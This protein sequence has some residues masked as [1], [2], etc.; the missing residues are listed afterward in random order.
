[1]ALWLIERYGVAVDSAIHAPVMDHGDDAR[2][3]HAHIL[4][5]TRVITASGLGKKT[6]I[7][8][9]KVT[10]SAETLV[11]REVWETLLNDALMR[12][13]FDEAI[14]DRRTLEEQGIDRTPQIHIGKKSKAAQ[15][16]EGRETASD[17]DDEEDGEGDTES[18][19]SGKGDS[20]PPKA[21]QEDA[22]EDS[23]AAD[24]DTRMDKVYDQT[25]RG[26]RSDLVQEIKALNLKRAAFE[27]IPLDQQILDLEHLMEKLDS[28]IDRLTQLKE[29]TSLSSQVKELLKQLFEFISRDKADISLVHKNRDIRAAQK[30]AQIKRYGRAYREGIHSQMQRMESYIE[31]VQQKQNDYAAYKS[32]VDEIEQLIA[33]EHKATSAQQI[34]PGTSKQNE[35][36][37]TTE[38]S[39]RKLKLR[40]EFIKEHFREEGLINKENQVIIAKARNNDTTQTQNMPAETPKRYGADDNSIKENIKQKQGDKLQ[41]SD[42][43]YVPPSENMRAFTEEINR[44][45]DADEKR[46][47]A[48]RKADGVSG[49]F[50][51]GDKNEKWTTTEEVLRKRKETAAKMRE[52]IPPEYRA[53][54]YSEEELNAERARRQNRAQSGQQAEGGFKGFAENVKSRWDDVMKAAKGDAKSEGPEKKTRAKMSGQFNQASGAEDRDQST[55]YEYYD[56]FDFDI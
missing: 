11:I 28:R 30:A 13:G 4:F 56:G 55:S 45:M 19:K 49:E 52:N 29:K 38:E 3:H 9:D 39:L 31:I 7:L 17:D 33:Q 16:A 21:E 36:L 14:V 24:E 6:R 50:N 8:D 2:N 27:D 42:N 32:F 46:A 20:L 43:Y 51:A 10:G 34:T 40:G 54:P 5:T 35:T 15:D 53:E 44:H 26:W 37:I 22:S 25:D 23:I 1:M 48:E 47:A 41:S 12:A 18:G